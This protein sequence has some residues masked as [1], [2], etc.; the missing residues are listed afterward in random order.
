MPE[1]GPSARGLRVFGAAGRYVQGWG[2]LD[3]LG[4][5]V[6]SLSLGSQGLVLIDAFLFDT[7]S[8]RIEASF[9]GTGRGTGTGIGTAIH[10]APVSAE[11]TQPAIDVIADAVPAGTDFVVGVGG[12]KTIDIA[13][14]VSRR[15]G[16]R[17]VTVPTIASN[18]SPASRAIAMYD[19]HHQLT[20]V[21]LMNHN[22]ALVLVDTQV[23]AGAPARFL[24]AG[25]GDALSKHFEVEATRAAGGTTMQGTP[26]LLIASIVGEGCYRTLRA[27]AV[28]ALAALES[29]HAQQ[30]DGSGAPGTSANSHR[31][32]TSGRFGSSGGPGDSLGQAFEDT[33]EAVVLLSGL[34]FENGGLSIA[35]ALTRGLMAVPGASAHLHGEHVAYGLLVQQALTGAPDADLRDLSAFLAAVGLPRSLTELGVQPT[36]APA[37]PTPPP[38]ESTSSPAE[39][40]EPTA[41][42]AEAAFA[43]IVERTLTAPHVVNVPPS[44]PV[45]AETLTSALRRVESLTAP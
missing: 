10:C 30:S 45:T 44:T 35:H 23:M 36:A 14:G 18:D 31:S 2:A 38:A 19:E 5:Q 42:P 29:H 15:L 37:E 43:A 27:N 4:P 17:V 34:A 21:P 26:G 1:A 3:E 9:A 39:P 7:L 33:V 40:A 32:T 11:V 8:P 25:I 41:E 20:S 16:L 13:K 28:A 12:G 24:S 22:P 6:T